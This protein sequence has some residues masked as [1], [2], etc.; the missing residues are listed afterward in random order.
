MAQR[1]ARKI[2][3]NVSTYNKGAGTDFEQGEYK[4]DASGATIVI[5]EYKTTA[6]LT[7]VLT[8]EF[9]HALGLEHVEN[10]ASIMFSYNVGSGL[11]LS[12]EDI[13]ELKAVCRIK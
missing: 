9:G 5:N 6:D 7:R 2:N 10:P 11:A 13:G 3:A 8:H 12:D 1:A 4:K